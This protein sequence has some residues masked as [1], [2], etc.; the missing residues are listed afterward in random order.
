MNT[1]AKTVPAVMLRSA[2]QF[3]MLRPYGVE[4]WMRRDLMD[5]MPDLA[6]TMA[7]MAANHLWRT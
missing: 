3:N 2:A 4:R 1:R 7:T 5:L 6:K